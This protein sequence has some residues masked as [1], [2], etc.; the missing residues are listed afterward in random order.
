MS[1]L[2]AVFLKIN[3]VVLKSCE[4]LGMLIFYPRLIVLIPVKADV[5]SCTS[6]K[7]F[8]RSG[9][10]CQLY[11]RAYLV[12]AGEQPLGSDMSSKSSG[13]G[14]I[15][16]AKGGLAGVAE[17]KLPKQDHIQHICC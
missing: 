12:P 8:R 6:S 5:L 7:H 13:G 16:R 2:N 15:P 4:G 11:P 17:D 9:L 3:K 1:F 10:G 14:N